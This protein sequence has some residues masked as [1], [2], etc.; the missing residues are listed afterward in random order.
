MKRRPPSLFARLPLA[1]A[2]LV[3]LVGGVAGCASSAAPQRTAP[4]SQRVLPTNDAL[5]ASL[6]ATPQ[7]VLQDTLSAVGETT[8]DCRSDGAR[9]VW[10]P[11]GSDATLVD[12]AR[13]SVGTVAPGPDFTA[14]DGSR[15][16]GTVAA[17]EIMTAGALTWQRIVP[18]KRGDTPRAHGRFA[19][20]TSVQRVLTTGGIPPVASCFQ[21]GQSLFVPYT[22]TYLFY[23]AARATAG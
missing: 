2:S 23:R 8:Y 17:E 15:F 9:L 5:P 1:T 16:A 6:R 14:Y 10:T 19:D 13:R 22:A 11:A 7:E 3:L 12:L 21:V 4:A 18:S 20:V